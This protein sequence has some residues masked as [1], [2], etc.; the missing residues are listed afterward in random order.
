[1]A[2][3]RGAVGPAAAAASTGV[4]L[5]TVAGSL[6]GYQVSSLQR[7]LP[8]WLIVLGLITGLAMVAATWVVSAERP[9]ASVG[10]AV[11]SVG[12]FVP[13]WAGW[14]ELPE[15]SQ[16]LVLAFAAV[17]I[18]GVA[19]VGLRWSSAGRSSVP[20]GVIY[21]L[22][23]GAAVVHA[24][25]YDPLTDPGCARTCADVQPLA[26][27]FLSSRMAYAVATALIVGSAV[28]AVIALG[29]DAVRDRSGVV[30]WAALLAVMVLTVPWISHTAAWT[31]PPSV[32]AAV[33][34]GVIA[35]LLIG[36]APVV[37]AAATHRMR[38]EVRGLVERLSGMGLAAGDGGGPMLGVQFTV[39]D[40]GRWVDSFGVEVGPADVPVRALVVSDAAGPALRLVVP[41]RADPGTVLA[42]L[43]PATM[44]AL[45]N[46]RLAALSRARMAEVRAS[47]RR[48]VDASDVERQ[49]IERDLHDGAQQRL[50]S[51]SFQLSLARNRLVDGGEALDRADAHLREALARLRHLG[52][53]IFPATL[54]TEGLAAALEDLAQ[55]SDV[56]MTL[57]V[58]ELGPEPGRD[59]ALAAY[60]VVATVLAHASR[61]SGSASADVRAAPRDGTLELRVQ[62]LGSARLEQ[63][64][65][66]DVADRV[67]A[68]GGRLG[69][70]P[71]DGG[72]AIIALMPCA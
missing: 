4:V 63:D 66:V 58:R 6:P 11:A 56:P 68:V 32:D 14:P 54:A 43:T 12:L 41:R 48:I 57:D 35:G 25:G 60:A 27:A 38:V 62:L 39:P 34:P 29:R 70:E 36:L 5:L 24:V 49:R 71:I 17:A 51:A 21:V 37:A 53:G 69:V 8:A 45:Q 9:S 55:T 67:G 40:N 10:L 72:V 65:L 13:I 52:H 31:D 18:A 59:V 28:V 15:L 2:G 20:L 23:V 3:V 50:V 47:Q 1:V 44:L 33:V 42:T 61:L 30:T 26:S 16:A 46:A 22:A 64:A 19:Q 7:D